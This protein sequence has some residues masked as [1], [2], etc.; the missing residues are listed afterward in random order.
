VAFALAE[1]VTGGII[2][3]LT[4][5][6]VLVIVCPLEIAVLRILIGEGV[7]AL[8]ATCYIMSACSNR[9]ALTATPASN[10]L[11]AHQCGTNWPDWFVGG[12]CL[13]TQCG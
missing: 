8:G 1:N 2:Q 5:A 12:I 6:V 9:F 7:A 4:A 3:V 10:L 11:R 13:I